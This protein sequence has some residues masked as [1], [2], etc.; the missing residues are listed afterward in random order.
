L[1]REIHL[2][3]LLHQ[4]GILSLLSL[5]QIVITIS[6]DLRLFRMAFSILGIS[7]VSFT[8]LGLEQERHTPTWATQAS[9]TRDRRISVF[10]K[11]SG[12]TC[13]VPGGGMKATS[14][15]SHYLP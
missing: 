12:K 6:M 13:P 7:T 3:W 15:I 8:R 1:E 9:P 2:L 5:I 4:M 10:I 11:G 14:P